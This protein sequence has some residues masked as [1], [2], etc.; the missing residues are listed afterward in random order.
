M[1]DDVYFVEANVVEGNAVRTVSGIKVNS[2]NHTIIII[3]IINGVRVISKINARNVVIV[4]RNGSLVS[5]MAS[6]EAANRA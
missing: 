1:G 2:N 5:R 4:I 3:I 6:K